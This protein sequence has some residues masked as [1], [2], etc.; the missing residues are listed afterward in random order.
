MPPPDGKAANVHMYLIF[1]ETGIIGLHFATDG[2]GVSS[3]I[4]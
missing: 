1:L 2:M 4:F 3:L